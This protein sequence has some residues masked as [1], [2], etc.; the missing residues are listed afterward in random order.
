MLKSGVVVFISISVFLAAAHHAIATG[1]QVM[2]LQEKPTP[3]VLANMMFPKENKQPKFKLRGIRF[4]QPSETNSEQVPVA[5]QQAQ[6][7]IK[8]DTSGMA[9][10]FN[11]QFAFNSA[12]LLP[13]SFDYLNTVGEMLLLQQTENAKLKIAGH[14]DAA[15]EKQYNQRLSESRA[16][17]VIVYLTEHFDIAPQRLSA[18]GYGESTPIPNTDPFDGIN[19]RVEFHPL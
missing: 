3:E 10:G 15:G 5:K 4:T 2:L 1:K 11:I 8:D 16:Q 18:I 19:R 12:T 6:N 13:E 14:A 7:D 9:V 17:A